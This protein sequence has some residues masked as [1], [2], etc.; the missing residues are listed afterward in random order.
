[1][2]DFWELEKDQ[3][4]ARTKM[5][6]GALI[7]RYTRDGEDTRGKDCGQR[8]GG[9]DGGDSTVSDGDLSGERSDLFE[10]RERAADAACAVCDVRGFTDRSG[11]DYAVG[12]GGFVCDAQCG[13]SGAGVWGDDGGRECGDRVCRD[14]AEGGA[15]GGVR[16]LGLWGDEGFAGSGEP[17]EDADGEELAEECACGVER[18]EFT[19]GSR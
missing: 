8:T 13:E 3:T 9:V 1:M 4:T 16:A 17:G 7:V 19:G 2:T 14:G 6:R 11:V 15:C 10:G 18:G 12:A 5:R